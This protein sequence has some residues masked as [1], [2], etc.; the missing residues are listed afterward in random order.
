MIYLTLNIISLFC[1]PGGKS[2]TLFYHFV[3]AIPGSCCLES[4]LKR[5]LKEAEFVNVSNII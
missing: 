1:S 3:G 4:M 5:L 2:W